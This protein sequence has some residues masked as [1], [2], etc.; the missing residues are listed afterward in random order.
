MVKIKSTKRKNSYL[1][2]L[3]QRERV[4]SRQYAGWRKQFESSYISRLRSRKRSRVRNQNGGADKKKSQKGG[5]SLKSSLTKMKKGLI[6]LKNDIALLFTS[7]KSLEKKYKDDPDKVIELIKR[8]TK[9]RNRA[10]IIT[11][12]VAVL[13]GS[14]A[15]YKKRQ[16]NAAKKKAEDEKYYNTLGLSQN[17]SKS[18]LKKA[19]RKLSLKWHPDRNRGNEKEA[20]EKFKEISEAYDFL[21]EKDVNKN[22]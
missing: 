1:N 2:R 12:I 10:L 3:R 20:N 16:S 13:A 17:A 7:K 15:M 5:F 14:A 6:N 21:Q 19:Y 8:K 11:A 9:I 18:D 4:R 22:R